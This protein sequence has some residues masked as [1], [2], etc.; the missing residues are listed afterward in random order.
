[1]NP[2]K[3]ILPSILQLR[4]P[5]LETEIDFE[6][7]PPHLIN[8]A[9][10]YHTDC[11]FFAQEMNKSHFLSKKMQHDFLFYAIRKYKRPFPGKWAKKTEE[12]NDR[13]IKVIMEALNYSYQKAQSVF[14]LLSAETIVK[15]HEE[16]DEGGRI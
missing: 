10:S 3:D 2:F 9:L 1:M 11:L 16:F 5:V 15:L 4:N 6:S 14:P 13:D 12:E 8:K 7:Y